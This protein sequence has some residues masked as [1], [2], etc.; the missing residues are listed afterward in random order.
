MSRGCVAACSTSSSATATSSSRRHCSS[1]SSRCSPAAAAICDLRT[2]KLVDQLSGRTIGLRADITPQVGAHRCPPVESSRVVARLCYCG[3]VL[4]TLPAGLLASREPLQISA[5]LY[6]H[7]GR[8]G[9]RD[10]PPAWRAP[11]KWP[12]SQVPASTLGHVGLFRALVAQTELAAAPS[13]KYLPPCRPRMSRHCGN[14]YDRTGAARSALLALPECYGG[15]EVLEEAARRLPAVPLCAAALDTLLR[16]AADLADLPNVP[17]G[18]DLADLRGTTVAVAWCS[19]PMAT[20]RL[21]RW[22][23]AAVTTRSAVIRP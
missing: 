13:R 12:P 16:L 7:A 6:G 3:S 18:F 9:Q 10:R 14:W 5:E 1:T 19:P 21:A 22:R 4:H 20:V 15:A 8:S 23:W 11:W 2:F 17:V